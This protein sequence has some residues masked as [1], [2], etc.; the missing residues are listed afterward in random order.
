M[1]DASG[2]YTFD[3]AFVGPMESHNANA[4]I[5]VGGGDGDDIII[6]GGLAGFIVPIASPTGRSSARAIPRQAPSGFATPHRTAS[7]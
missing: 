6:N 3:G 1:G 7:R 2:P 5:D 4:G